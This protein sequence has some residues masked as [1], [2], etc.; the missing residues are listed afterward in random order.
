MIIQALPIIAGLQR[1]FRDVVKRLSHLT[2]Y[3]G[4]LAQLQRAFVISQRIACLALRKIGIANIIQA[5]R[6]TIFIA[7]IAL[8]LQRLFIICQ[9]VV[10]FPALAIQSAEVDQR[11]SQ[12]F[13][14]AYFPL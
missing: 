7:N 8:D 13:L 6:L 5:Y 11:H 3:I 12:T 9:C 10:I 2:R 4:F 1:C 14:I